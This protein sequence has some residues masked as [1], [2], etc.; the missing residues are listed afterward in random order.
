MERSGPDTLGGETLLLEQGLDLGRETIVMLAPAAF[1]RPPPQPGQE[2]TDLSTAC[3]TTKAVLACVK[4][5][6]SEEGLSWL[7]S[8]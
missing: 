4:L 7:V 6:A 5:P 2:L 3:P 1:V 8:A